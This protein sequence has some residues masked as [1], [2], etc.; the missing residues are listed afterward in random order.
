[1]IEASIFLQSVA[2]GQQRPPGA[3]E[4]VDAARV[5]DAVIRSCE[6]GLWETCR[7]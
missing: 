6:T 7:T 2:D 1:V 5:A 3:A 4:M